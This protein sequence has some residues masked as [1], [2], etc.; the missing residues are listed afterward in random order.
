M[1]RSSLAVRIGA[2]SV[3]IAILTAI[4]AGALTAGLVKNNGASAARANLARLADVAQSLVTHAPR[5]RA[6][7]ARIRV[8]LTGLN[9]R[10]G[11]I[12][13]GGVVTADAPIIK[14]TLTQA[15]IKTVLGGTSLSLQ[16]SI[17]GTD[18]FIEARPTPDGAVVL[19][20]RRADALAPNQQAI[21]RTLVAL[22]IA[23]A[24]AI[25]LGLWVAWRLARPLRRTAA[26]AHALADGEREVAVPTG[27]PREVAEVADAIT[28]LA[29][30]LRTSEGRQR[31]FLMSVSHDLRTPLTAIR[32]YAESLAEGAVDLEET[33]RVGAV[34]NAE[35]VRMEALV[36]DLLD[37]ARL[38]A[39]DFLIVS[40]PLDLRALM[41]A[42][43]EVYGTRSRVEGVD[44]AVE[45]PSQP[46]LVTT[47]AQRLRQALDGLFDN[48]LR[49][50]PQGGQ[51]A[52]ALRA[53]PAM[54]VIEVRDSG[55][56][57]AD[58][59]LPVAFTRGAL[60]QRYRGER[61]VGSGL[62]LAIVH[63]LITRLGGTTEAAHAPEGGACF[64]LRIPLSGGYRPPD[65]Q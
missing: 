57:L 41:G 63:G 14:Q 44:F 52:V 58:E 31:D 8:L 60:Y 28:S 55:P 5:A 47:D 6:T 12:S 21:R 2:L 40:A 48:A 45:L 9:V 26:A 33:A 11:V 3:S 49:M 24:A 34:M 23:A 19:A 20:Q 18:V 1:N 25:V 17:V 42:A 4:L 43:A 22:L 51:I 16:R 39:D 56:G 27:G 30:A 35:A 54:A 61:R 50:T 15:E 38:D 65:S 29:S 62:G 37:L 64:R 32:G 10:S 36:N 7:E 53:E 46:L 13:S 59:D